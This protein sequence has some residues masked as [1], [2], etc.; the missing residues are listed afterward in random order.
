MSSSRPGGARL[1]RLR[2]LVQ[3]ITSLSPPPFHCPRARRVFKLGLGQSPFPVAPS[4]VQALRD[5]AHEKDY[6]PVQGLLSLR[7]AVAGYFRDVVGL[8]DERSAA[9][10][11]V[12]PGSKE[13]LFLIQLVFYGDLLL[14]N[15]SWVS[16]APQADIIGRNVQWLPTRLDEDWKLQPSVLRAHADRAVGPNIPRILL[17]NTPSNPT[18]CSMTGP[19]LQVRAARA[20]ASAPAR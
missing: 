17:L 12:G 5:R 1:E 11:L 15:P 16:Y 7:E 2:P 4:M 9:D 8:P 20:L 13:L 6:L 10:V 18:G 14:P 19:E 3:L